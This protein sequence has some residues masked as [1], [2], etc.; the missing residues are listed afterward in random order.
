MRLT[1]RGF[2]CSKTLHRQGI[3][4]GVMCCNTVNLGASTKTLVVPIRPSASSL[5][6]TGSH[7]DIGPA[8]SAGD[9]AKDVYRLRCARASH[10]ELMPEY[11]TYLVE[12]TMTTQEVLE[13]LFEAVQD[14]RTEIEKSLGN[15]LG[16][17]DEDAEEMVSLMNGPDD[18]SDEQTTPGEFKAQQTGFQR[19]RLEYNGHVYSLILSWI[20]KSK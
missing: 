12:V 2:T 7:Q 18:I 10:T 3:R 16:M 20:A 19:G 1:L 17:S 8:Q 9:A 11:S 13:S 6:G 15:A 14:D 4:P 5:P